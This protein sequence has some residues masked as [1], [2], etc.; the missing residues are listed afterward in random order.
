MDLRS[1]LP[2]HHSIRIHLAPQLCGFMQSRQALTAAAAQLSMAHEVVSPGATAKSFVYEVAW[3]T[4]HI[5]VD[6]K[7]NFAA[8]FFICSHHIPALALAGR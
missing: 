4:F 5:F 1:L 6:F 3:F 2:L 8:R 7:N